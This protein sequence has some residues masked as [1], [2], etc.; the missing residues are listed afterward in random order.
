MNR[1][2]AEAILHHAV[3][4]PDK[5]ALVL[6]EGSYT[7]AQL[8]FAAKQIAVHLRS[9]GVRG[10]ERIIVESSHSFSYVAMDYG[11]QLA[12]GV[13]VPLEKAAPAERYLEVRNAVDAEYVFLLTQRPEIPD[14]VLLESFLADAQKESVESFEYKGHERDQLVEIL[15]TTGTTG[16]SKGVMVSAHNQVIMAEAMSD[17]IKLQTKEVWLVPTPL[18]HAGGLRKMYMA[19][20][21]GATAALLDGFSNMKRFFKFIEEKGVTAI[22]LP[23]AAIHMLLLFGKKE[24]AALDGRL[25]FLYSSSSTYPQTDKNAMKE[26]LPH[27][28]M[29]NVYG[30]SE[31]GGVCFVNF[32]GPDDRPGSIGKPNAYNE[33]YVL[34]DQYQIIPHSDA[35]HYGYIASKSE[36]V[37]LGYW[38][39]PELT[40]SVLKNG[41]LVT[42]DYGYIDQDGNVFLIGRANDVINVG[43]MKVAPTEV[44]DKVLEVEGVGECMLIPTGKEDLPQLKLLLVLKEGYELET[45]TKAVTQHLKEN[46]EA[47][48][49]PKKIQQVPEIKKTFNGKIDRKKMIADYR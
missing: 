35:E 37:M 22:Y 36:L 11:V 34:D 17:A 28:T 15:F 5:P 26:L 12:G 49:L 48:K 3:E 19:L 9:I 46:V 45:V 6:E 33:I 43:G 41:M 16:K 18:N 42:S 38:N 1:S 39:E 23:P 4:I 24:L 31:S 21:V 8:A 7:F 13:F 32:N 14:A 44:E 40:A 10:G 47:Y 2:I 30:S 25:T 20:Y 29:Y 27:V